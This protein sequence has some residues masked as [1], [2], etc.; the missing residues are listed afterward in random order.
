MNYKYIKIGMLV[1]LITGLFSCQK[2]LDIVPDN[3]ATLDNAFTLRSSAEKYFFTCYSYL[4]DDGDFNSNAGFNTGNEVW[5]DEPL[6]DVDPDFRNIARGLQNTANPLGN[7]WSG[8]NQGKPLYQGIRDCN[9]FLANIDKV[10]EMDEFEKGQWAA[11]VTFLKAYYHFYLMR[12]YGPIPLIKEN[13]PISSNNV[14]VYRAPVDDC[15]NYIVSLLDTCINSDFLPERIEGTESTDLGRITKC[16]AI[17]LK[18]KVLV[19]AASPLFNGNTA[20][21]DLKDNQNR[22]LVSATFDS[23]KWERA[24]KACKEAIDYC[25]SHGYGLYNYV[26]NYSYKTNDTINTQLSIRESITAKINNPEVIWPNTNSM[27]HNI[28]RWSM[29]LIAPGT[30][31]SGPKGLIAPP[32]STAELFYTKNGLPIDED[33]TWDYNGRFSLKTAQEKDQFYIH[34]GETT[35]KLHFDREPRFYADL[36]FD[37]GVWFG[38][39]VGNYDVSNLYYIKARKGETAA[40]QG[41]SNYSVTGY[42]PKKLVNIETSCEADGKIT[43]STEDYPWPEMRMSDLYLLY[44]EAANEAYGPSADVYDYINRIR[45]RAGLPT[46]EESWTNYAKDP[47][48]YETKEGMRDIIHHERQIELAFEGQSYWDLKRWKEA[49]N[50]YNQPVRGWS[51]E[52]KDAESYYKPVLL[53]NQRFR[54]RDYL[55]PIELN[56][57]QINRN[58]VQNP[59]W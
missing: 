40:R 2:Y 15:V 12:M 54:S 34:K 22:P 44:A 19:T 35:A 37:R 24:A 39:W 10:K 51:I 25:E 53:F 49:I 30:N 50:V 28:Q 20:Y 5:Y 47:S 3:I 17:A 1:I 43:S 7:F 23:K 42:W 13:L 31:G 45:E 32:I 8:H 14:Q 52:Q 18:A 38:N 9:T 16:I 57:M 41:I 36:G 33:K 26:Q 59:G 29:A 11:E 46:V 56:E 27:A 48:K 58:L 21:A 6:R 4:P 55:W